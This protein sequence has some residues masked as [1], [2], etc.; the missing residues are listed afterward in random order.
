M[1]RG[2]S[3]DGWRD[4]RVWLGPPGQGGE[5]LARLF[6]LPAE[7]DVWRK[8]ADLQAS[9]SRLEEELRKLTRSPI[10]A[11][12][13]VSEPSL[14][15]PQQSL[16]SI[17]ELP[18]VLLRATAITGFLAASSSPSMRGNAFSEWWRECG[19]SRVSI[20][21]IS[22]RCA[23][24]ASA[25]NSSSSRSTMSRSC[26]PRRGQSSSILL[27]RRG[28]RRAPAIASR[29][30]P[31]AAART[32]SLARGAT[33]RRSPRPV[34]RASRRG[35]RTTSRA[36]LLIRPAPTGFVVLEVCGSTTGE[37]ADMLLFLWLS[38]EAGFDLRSMVRR[39]GRS[40][41]GIL[42]LPEQSRS[43]FVSHVDP[44]AG[45]LERRIRVALTTFDR[46]PGT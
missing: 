21:L 2:K 43:C 7:R 44:I 27:S 33:G 40:D 37:P 6:G 8:L 4:S 18:R 35:N 45:R 14:A 30:A 10:G 34:C 36:S 1:S 11:G 5:R 25:G 39:G 9:V 38:P 28:R 3:L 20:G 41:R 17:I 13:N 19:S 42:F 22:S 16:P 46:Q 26:S 12:S 32:P 31:D 15:E 24:G 29:A 23:V